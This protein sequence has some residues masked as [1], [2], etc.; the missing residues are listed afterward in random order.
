MPTTEN[1]QP[2]AAASGPAGRGFSVETSFRGLCGKTTLPM[3]LCESG[4]L[5]FLM[6]NEAA[7]EL[8]G[9]GIVETAGMKLGELCLELDE[10]RLL[11]GRPL[12][13]ALK[14][15]RGEPCEVELHP[16][17]TY[18]A[19]SDLLLLTAVPLGGMQVA[20]IKGRE[21]E[22]YLQVAPVAVLVTDVRDR[23]RLWNGRSERL[24]GWP[25]AEVVGKNS[26]EVLGI[27]ELAFERASQTVRETGEWEGELAQRT[28]D[29]RAVTVQSRWTAVTDRAGRIT[30][31]VGVNADITEQKNLEAQ[32]LRAQR[33]ESIGTLTSGVA[34][35][36]NNILTPIMMSAGILKR[37]HQDQE[38]QRL[39]GAIEGSAE[40]GADIV[41]QV[42]T[43]ARGVVGERMLLQPRHLINELAR[44]VGQT[45]PKNIAL[46][47]DA[48]RDLWMVLGDATQIHQILLNL[49]V[50]ARDAMPQGGEL[51]LIARNV[52]FG[53]EEVARHPDANPG[54]H[55]LI[56][57]RDTGTGISE[58]LLPKI[59]DP[60]FTT[61][62]PGHGT[63]LGL[64]TVRGLVRGHGGLLSV[65]TKIGEG[66]AFQIYL[67]ASPH[68]T[69]VLEQEQ[70]GP[71]IQGRGEGVLVVDDEV[72]VRSIAART[73][74]ANGYRVFLAED[75]SDGLA[76]CMQRAGEI[77]AIITD[78]VMEEVDGVKFAETVRRHHPNIPI[79]VSSGRY[80]PEQ[81]TVFQELGIDRFLDK[82]YKP[83]Q[84]LLAVS[85]VLHPEQTG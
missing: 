7:I 20:E 53:K 11:L 1:R 84:L 31:V 30:A 73:L 29:G 77:A 81:R 44:I 36:L 37:R 64:A 62:E 82:P 5:R 40:R 39:L 58:D 19:G 56:E 27:D 28:K 34:H 22:A 65:A 45:F 21:I 55:I 25:A 69:V 51:H 17:R 46:H 67:P 52:V 71:I 63:G 35:D 75:G 10:R 61:K 16:N 57:V 80:T 78:V 9:F 18:F 47:A 60:F 6:L 76:V 14:S 59:F 43:F 4:T 70:K 12:R 26:R 66:T 79:I 72:T 33:V 68:G 50:N 24:Y 48:P 54:P 32:Y 42:L 2:T 74:E 85:G 23:I 38:S 83:E 3:W 41:R 15:K 13:V 8:L 49:C